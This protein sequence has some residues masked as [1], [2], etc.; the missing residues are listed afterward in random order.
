MLQQTHSSKH[1]DPVQVV[2]SVPLWYIFAG[3]TAKTHL[4]LLVLSITVSLLLLKMKSQCHANVWMH[5]K[6]CDN[7]FGHKMVLK[8]L[9]LTRAGLTPPGRSVA[10]WSSSAK[11][12]LLAQSLT[13]S[14]LIPPA[15]WP[16][17]LKVKLLVC[18]RFSCVNVLVQMAQL[19]SLTCR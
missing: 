2:S 8:W 19:T 9:F 5:I 16:R 3:N 11:P 14:Q 15:I 7:E 1:W 13:K 17:A 10:N 4:N 6:N 12:V 18:F